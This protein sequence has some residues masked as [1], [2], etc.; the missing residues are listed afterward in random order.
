MLTGWAPSAYRRS[1]ERR[2]YTVGKERDA[3]GV[4]S[5]VRGPRRD[6]RPVLGS[7]GAGGVSRAPL[8][9]LGCSPGAARR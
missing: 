9:S 8:A 4:T 2:T 7:G 1:S 5:T 3:L 6:R